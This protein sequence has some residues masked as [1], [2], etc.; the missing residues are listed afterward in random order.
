MHSVRQRRVDYV[1]S[2][3]RGP[4]EFITR[5]KE[6]GEPLGRF[7]S[8]HHV[9][10]REWVT[11]TIDFQAH[12]H[13]HRCSRPDIF[14]DEDVYRAMLRHIWEWGRLY[15]LLR[16]EKGVLGF[17]HMHIRDELIRVNLLQ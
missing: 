16:K 8:E 15:D 7:V 4:V 5:V 1:F 14:S 6:L 2:E 9:K 13:E 3:C 10:F 11:E 17:V 12:F